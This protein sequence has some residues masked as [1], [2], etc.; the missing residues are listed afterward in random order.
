[1]RTLVAMLAFF[2]V[3]AAVNLAGRHPPA[4]AQDKAG[5]VKWEYG[6]LGTG[7]TF[8][9]KAAP[10][11]GDRPAALAGRFTWTTGT[12][13]ISAETWKDLAEKLKVEVKDKDA[14]LRTIR[15]AVLNHLGARGWEMVA[16]SGSGPAPS[17][18]FKRRVP[19]PV[20]VG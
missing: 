19:W 15:V 14:Q 13:D 4:A 20:P 18:T 5:T 8:G 3:I 12:E 17:Y 2:G 1:M 11:G 6:M 7:A 9:G 10:F 16:E